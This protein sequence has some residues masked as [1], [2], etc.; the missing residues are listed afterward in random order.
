[1]AKKTNNKIKNGTFR[2]LILG[3]ILGISGGILLSGNLLFWA[4][5]NI[6]DNNK[7]TAIT[8][9]LIK[10]PDIQKSIAKYGTDQLFSSVDVQGYIGS[11]L[12]PKASFLAPTLA[13]Q[14]KTV[15]DQQLQKSLSNPKVQEIWNNSLSK[16]HNLVIKAA[17]NYKG[18]GT[19]DLGQLFSFATSNLKDTKLSF[20]SDKKLPSNVGQIELINASWLPIVHNIVVNIDPFEYLMTVLFIGLTSVAIFISKNRRTIII[21]ISLL[22]SGIML[23]TVIGL[24]FIKMLITNNTSSDY[25]SAATTAYSI[26]T[27]S[28]Y[29]QSITILVLG[30]IIALVA[31]ISGEYKSA[32]RVKEI[33]NKLLSGNIHKAIFKHE[34]SYTKFIG[35]NRKIINWA[36]VVI[37]AIL[38][39]FVGISLTVLVTYF[40]VIILVIFVVEISSASP[41][42]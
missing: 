24:R 37:A 39:C 12:P 36:S 17:T 19:I 13:E 28:F 34:N 42:S 23:V 14:L 3:L 18:N 41:K 5:N 2:N 8:A 15:V 9:P 31:W 32:K 29:I 33:S 30:L 25:S 22:Y 40:I 21:K 4:G 35:K 7:F 27:K 10:Q 20:L 1:M 26:V 11:V 6:V 38:L 16:T